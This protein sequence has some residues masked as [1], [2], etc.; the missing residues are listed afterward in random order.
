[1]KV[2]KTTNRTSVITF[3][4]LA[5]LVI[6]FA[7][8][9]C[10]PVLPLDGVV[11]ASSLNVRA[12]ATPG[13]ITPIVGSTGTYTGSSYDG[14]CTTSN[15]ADPMASNLSADVAGGPLVAFN[16]S[17]NGHAAFWNLSNGSLARASVCYLPTSGWSVQ[18]LGDFNGD[19][20]TDVIWR[21]TSGD[22]AVWL[23]SGSTRTA[24]ALVANIPVAYN[25]EGVAD[26]DGDLKDD[27]LLR[28]SSSNL[29]ILKMNGTGTP[30][31]IALGAVAATAHLS[32][33]GSYYDTATGKK[34]IALF[35]ADSASGSMVVWYMSGTAVA[36][37]VA[38][39]VGFTTTGATTYTILGIGDFNGDGNSD[40]L[41]QDPAGNILI[42]YAV[43]NGVS[44]AVASDSGSN[45]PPPV[46]WTLQG[47][48]RINNDIYSDWVWIVS[49]GVYPSL[50]YTPV[51]N[52]PGALNSIGYI[53]PGWS[54][55]KYSHL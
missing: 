31:S 19:Y 43:Y 53:R 4:I 15:T 33:I 8:Q 7:F 29:T 49:T 47:V 11:D 35:F 42:R 26:F 48:R 18:A 24:T 45:L 32:E 28:D 54:F 16:N 40:L 37:Q 52:T 22:T 23:M 17:S 30:T 38:L 13:P 39:P 46:S 50:A 21:N 51:A 41:L 5:S 25:I 44:L 9:N 27:L 12:T 20:N 34:K 10:A 55:F 36:S 2:S 3:G 6:L 1:M 14:V